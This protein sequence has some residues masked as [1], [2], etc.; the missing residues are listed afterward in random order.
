MGYREQKCLISVKIKWKHSNINIFIL[1]LVSLNGGL[2]V[3]GNQYVENNLKNTKKIT[4]KYSFYTDVC[5]LTILFIN[6]S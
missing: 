4:K 1:N 3:F 5:L 2:T 6:P